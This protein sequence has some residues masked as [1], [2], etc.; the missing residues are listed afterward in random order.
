MGSE[1]ERYTALVRYL[2]DWCG[3]L[4]PQLR[5]ASVLVDDNWDMNVGHDS[6]KHH[7]ANMLY[8]LSYDEPPPPITW[9]IEYADDIT[10]P[11]CSTPMASCSDAEIRHI[12]AKQRISG[13]LKW[14]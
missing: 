10:T 7:A 3:E 2:V 9:G 13:E 6:C 8:M 1:L 14:I 11:T 4:N 12:V 5:K